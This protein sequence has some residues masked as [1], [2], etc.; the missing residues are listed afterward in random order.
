MSKPSEQELKAALEQAAIMRESGADP[1]FLAKTLL[2]HHYRLGLLEAVYQALERYL[3]SGLAEAEHQHLLKV[4]DK[5]RQAEDHTA[6]SH[7]DEFGLA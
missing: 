6:G 3:R 7:P 5:V 1:H 4:M 2:S